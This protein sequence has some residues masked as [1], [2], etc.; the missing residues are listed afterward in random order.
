MH[1]KTFEITSEQQTI[2]LA[3]NL[4]KIAKKGYVFA[5]YGDLGAG[6]TF[7]T[8]AFAKAL[9]VNQEITSPTYVLMNEYDGIEKI[10]HLDL[11][12]LEAFE[13]VL[14]LGL[15]ELIEES[16]CLIEW[17]EVAEEIFPES[18]IKMY[19]TYHQGQNRTIKIES[20]VPLF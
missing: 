13:E 3:N 8:R 14:E 9:K 20:N 2:D 4:A 1:V 7:F 16:I 19:F 18:T 15:V 12:R 5:L 17:P 10:Y 11:Y 6:K